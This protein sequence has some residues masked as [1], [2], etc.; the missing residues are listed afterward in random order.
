MY[1]RNIRKSKPNNYKNKQ[2]L[3]SSLVIFGLLKGRGITFAGY[4][5]PIVINEASSNNFWR[6][7]FNFDFFIFFERVEYTNN[8]SN[9]NIT[10]N[11]NYLVKRKI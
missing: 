11:K 5:M 4:V 2:F 1:P 10:T 7:L 9:F 8:R 6:Y 3:I